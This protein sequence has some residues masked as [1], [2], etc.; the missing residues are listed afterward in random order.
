MWVDKL[1][2]LFVA[3]AIFYCRRPIQVY[4]FNTLR[5][6]SV[7]NMTIRFSMA[8]FKLWFSRTNR[9]CKERK[10]RTSSICLN[11]KRCAI[12]FVYTVLVHMNPW[13]S[14]FQCPQYGLF[15]LVNLWLKMFT[16]TYNSAK[17]GRQP[18]FPMEICNWSFE[19]VAQHLETISY[20]G[21]LALSCDVTKLHATFR[22]YLDSVIRRYTL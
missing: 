11:E 20:N 21:L 9:R 18:R 15:G 1:L 5:V 6:H 2:I 16:H 10:C 13:R 4:M 12:L 7:G 17:E 3:W 22:L 14:S 8:F 19:L